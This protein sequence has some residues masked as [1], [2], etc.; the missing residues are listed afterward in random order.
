MP[1]SMRRGRYTAP[2][3]ELRLA[4]EPHTTARTARSP[5][6]RRAS[7]RRS[8]TAQDARQP[9]EDR[10]DRGHAC[11]GARPTT[12]AVT[13]AQTIHAPGPA[14]QPQSS[15]NEWGS[16]S[17]RA[18]ESTA[19]DSPC[20]AAARQS[21]DRSMRAWSQSRDG[22]ASHA[23]Q[24]CSLASPRARS[25]AARASPLQ[26]EGRRFESGRAHGPGRR[27]C[28]TA[29]GAAWRACTTVGRRPPAPGRPRRLFGPDPWD[30][31]PVIDRRRVQCDD[32]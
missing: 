18:T 21:T 5:R 13:S 3:R 6:R 7:A 9:G 26:G 8:P 28:R 25:S 14:S 20:T 32:S 15:K 4:G 31:R 16:A 1:R 27:I 2:R 12:L 10:A 24:G 19:T 23:V 22:G 30:P 17:A 11:A 29:G